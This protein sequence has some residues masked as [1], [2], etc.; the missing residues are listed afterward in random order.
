MIYSVTFKLDVKQDKTQAFPNTCFD[1]HSPIHIKQ[2]KT[3]NPAFPDTR[4]D[5][6]DEREVKASM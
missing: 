4:F 2:D 3:W 1:L 6:K 5:E